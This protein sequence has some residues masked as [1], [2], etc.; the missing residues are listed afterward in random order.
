MNSIRELLKMAGAVLVEEGWYLLAFTL[1]PIGVWA[2][3]K[4]RRHWYPTVSPGEDLA[5]DIVLS[6]RKSPDTAPS[7]ARAKEPDLGSQQRSQSLPSQG[8][9]ELIPEVRL[10]HRIARLHDEALSDPPV[11]FETDR[12]KNEVLAPL[13]EYLSDLQQSLA[14]PTV[15]CSLLVE[16]SGTS[17]SGETRVDFHNCERLIDDVPTEALRLEFSFILTFKVLKDLKPKYEAIEVD[18]RFAGD[19]QGSWVARRRASRHRPDRDIAMYDWYQL[20][21]RV[22]SLA[23]DILADF[24]D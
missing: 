16:G 24:L 6:P 12:L 3:R 13:C 5:A 7:L 22:S 11:P 2:Y 10:R 21:Q 15:R 23:D 14:L 8:S 19:G 18:G 17:A 20:K 4:I 1:I 9:Q